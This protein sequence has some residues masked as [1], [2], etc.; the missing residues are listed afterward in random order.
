MLFAKAKAVST[1][2]ALDTAYLLT[3]DDD[4]ATLGLT[5]TTDATDK[6]CIYQQVHEFYLTA[7]DGAK[8]WI[9]GVAIA[10]KFSD[11]V[12]TTTFKNL[13]RGTS[14]ANPD[15]RAKILGFSYEVPQATQ[16]A[17]DFNADVPLASAALKITQAALFQ[18]G[19]QFSCLID[20]NQMSAIIT[21]ATL[22]TIANRAEPQ[23]SWVITG[24]TKNGCSA[25]GEALGRFARITIG[26]G[27]G[28]V[29]DG[30]VYG[31]AKYLTNGCL[32]TIAAGGTL[33]AGIT[34]LV[35]VGKITYDG[36]DYL[37]GDT[38]VC[39]SSPVVFTTSASGVVNANATDITKLFPADIDSLGTKQ[40]LFHRIWFNHSGFFWNDG[41]TAE[42]DTKPLSTQEFNRVA[43]ALAADVLGFIINTIG[44]NVPINVSTGNVDEGYCAALQ[45]DFKRQYINP[46]SIN[47]GTGD[48]TDGAITISGTPSGTQVTWTF[49]LT[50]VPTP[51]VG[52]AS[53]TIEFSYTL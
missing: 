21:P 18:E 53:G 4:L 37:P 35:S 19:Y 26:H 48:L 36:I 30:P 41:A 43:N 50:I 22:A 24:N 34:Y 20:G 14:H 51:I 16:I 42:L 9:V 25:V 3:K 1:T 10:T 23:S 11:Y 5:A 33:T 29:N 49:A 46:K 28:C 12:A 32:V 27:F 52:G 6:V 47:G 44:S 17:T 15:N 8:I 2:F 31:S 38:F 39:K 45:E 7:G 40:Y 13:I